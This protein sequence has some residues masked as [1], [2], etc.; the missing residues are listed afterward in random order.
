LDATYLDGY[1]DIFAP[2]QASEAAAIHAGYFDAFEPT[3][4]NRLKWGASISSE[5]LEKLR[6]SHDQFRDAL[7]SLFSRFDLLML[8]SSPRS[9]LQ[10]N[11]DHSSVRTSI[12]RYTTPF[13]LGGNPVVSLSGEQLGAPCG[14][15]VQI[16][17]APGYDSL[18][19]ALVRSL[20]NSLNLAVTEQ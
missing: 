4:A 10:A 3:L 20:V 7:N 5:E 17:A 1:F 9:E 12:L 18:L 15:G 13:S 19:L 8:P 11:E 14:T 16:A 6:R 2:I